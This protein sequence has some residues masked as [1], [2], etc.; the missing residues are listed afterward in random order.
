ML[1]IIIRFERVTR[2]RFHPFCYLNVS[3]QSPSLGVKMTEIMNSILKADLS[4]H[5]HY[6]VCL[7]YFEIVCRFDKY[8]KMQN[9]PKLLWNVIAGFLTERGMR[10]PNVRVRSRL[11]FLFSRFVRTLK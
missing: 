2:Q 10:H 11:A 9:D 5:P 4:N 6:A 1:K 7:Y 8:F 3:F